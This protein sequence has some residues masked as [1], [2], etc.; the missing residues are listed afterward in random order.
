LLQ[1]ENATYDGKTRMPSSRPVD[2]DHAV[3]MALFGPA[4]SKILTELRSLD[5][6]CL[7]PIDALNILYR[8]SETAKKS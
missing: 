3:Q 6:S 1:L 7:T 4:D 8:L 2:G 5:V